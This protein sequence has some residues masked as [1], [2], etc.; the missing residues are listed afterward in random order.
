MAVAISRSSRPGLYPKPRE[1]GRK[2]SRRS[3]QGT[4]HDKEKRDVSATIVFPPRSAREIE[5][6]E[7][8]SFQRIRELM[9]RIALRGM[10]ANEVGRARISMMVRSKSSNT[11]PDT[12]VQDRTG[13]RSTR[14]NARTHVDPVQES[15]SEL[16]KKLE[17]RTREPAEA[18]EHQ[19]AT[20]EVLQVISS[21]FGELEPV[22]P[23]HAGEGDAH[24]PSRVRRN[25]ALRGRGTIPL[26]DINLLIC[27]HSCTPLCSSLRVLVVGNR[28]ENGPCPH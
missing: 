9:T 28:K 1:P 26:T 11:G 27:C 22:V 10:A 7:K 13:L 15:R 17:A 20:S 24:L 25:V 4:A 19:T 12:L 23:N 6:V 8:W 16:E 21:S 5:E 3:N 14:T 18:L 2:N